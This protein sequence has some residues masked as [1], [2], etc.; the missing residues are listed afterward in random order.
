MSAAIALVVAVAENGV[1]GRDGGLPWRVKAD[2]RK[3]RAI[4]MGK[5]LV[6]GRKTFESIGRALDGRDTIVVTRQPDFHAEGALVAASLAAALGV[7]EERARARRVD[8]ICVVGGGE[9]YREA[10]PQAERLYVTRVRAKP[11]GDACFPQISPDD[12]EEA[13]REALPASEGDTAT[14]VHVVYRKRR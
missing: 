8:E 10:L 12:W 1:I 6:M 11:E 4:T 14:A 7:A 5:P 13:E 3:F 9:V 2:M